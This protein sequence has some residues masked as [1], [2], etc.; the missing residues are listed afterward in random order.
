MPVKTLVEKYFDA[1]NNHKWDQLAEVFHPDVTLRHG[2]TLHTEGREKAVKLLKAVV[3]QFEE[4]EDRPTRYVIDG[5]V[6]AIEIQFTGNRPQGETMSFEAV[7]IIDTDGS[8][9]TK[10]VSWYDSAEVLPLIQG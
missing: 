7:D 3:G 4:H 10:V 8:S 6:A 1:V 2:M 5:N 9:I